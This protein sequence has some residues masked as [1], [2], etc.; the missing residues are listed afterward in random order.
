MNELFMEKAI[1]IAKKS[2]KDIPV[3]A[4]IVKDNKII[5][6]AFNNNVKNKLSTSH[7]EILAI[8]KACK[9]CK[10]NKLYDCEIYV[11]KEP[12]LMCMGAIINS[13]I[14]KLYF[15]CYDKRFSV[16]DKIDHFDFN[17]KV[18]CFGGIKEE[19]CSK[20]LTDFFN[21]LRGKKNG[22]NC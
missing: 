3:G 19:E 10:T 4:I 7:A 18:E 1:Y 14:K 9:K 5:S 22:D 20:L 15:G 2:K 21:N 8:E 17:H 11:T 6:M 13:R 16:V 12:C